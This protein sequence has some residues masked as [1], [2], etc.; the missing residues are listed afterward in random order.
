MANCIIYIPEVGE[1]L[2]HWAMTN[3]SGELVSAAQSGKLSEAS[4]SVA[5]KQ[6]IVVL[7][8]DNVLLAEAEVPGNSAARALQAIPYALEEQVADDIENLHFAVGKK[9]KG[10]HYPVA[11]INRDTMETLRDQLDDAGLRPTEVV[12]EILALPKLDPATS[13]P[14]WTGLIDDHN[15][16]VRLNG[17]KGFATDPDTAEIMLDGARQEFEE[18][19]SRGIVLF[20]TNHDTGEFAVDNL[21]VDARYCESRLGLYATGLANSPRI[22]LL[23][24]DFSYRQQLD[25][26]WKPWIW[27]A[28]LGLVLLGIFAASSLFDYVRLGD[29]QERLQQ[30]ITQTYTETFPGTRARRPIAQMKQQLK[31]L[32]APVSSTGFTNDM[33]IIAAAFSTQ[34]QSSINSLGYRPGRFDIDMSTDELPSLDKLKQEIEKNGTLRMSVQ[35]TRRQKDMVRSTIRLESSQ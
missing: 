23:Q 14:V 25:L 13:G 1:D 9:D 10:N 5:G 19:F 17:Y 12:P 20:H 18:E 16:V 21:D 15:A 2:A 24:G 33:A 32:G 29:Q 22:N 6:S 3:A 34:P 27:T 30:Q 31:A 26:A 11:V 28:V 8:G 35:S 4:A 7:P